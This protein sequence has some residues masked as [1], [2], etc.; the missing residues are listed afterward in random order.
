MRLM[1]TA[2]ITGAS[3]GLGKALSKVFRQHF[4]RVI[5]VGRNPCEYADADFAI[6]FTSPLQ[7]DI[8]AFSN[9]VKNRDVRMVILNAG[10]LEFDSISKF[11]SEE[12]EKQIRINSLGQKFIIDC[13]IA[14]SIKNVLF[15]AISSGA[16]VSP[17][18]G[19]GGYC[20]SK[21]SM[22]MLMQCYA[23]EFPSHRFFSVC[24]GLVKTSMQSKIFDS[25]PPSQTTDY[26]RSEYNSMPSAGKVA[27][28]IFESLKSIDIANNGDFLKL[29][30]G[31]L[32]RGEM[33]FSY[34]N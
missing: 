24:P 3:G 23:K 32:L 2:V 4:W 22:N 12:I 1:K 6:D 29:R 30:E 11:T 19:W 13:V 8:E 18:V 28:D 25:S 5:N 27:N 7:S 15:L 21:T 26:L 9:H 34:L 17:V 31:R 16:S 14:S 20:I 10:T 33:T